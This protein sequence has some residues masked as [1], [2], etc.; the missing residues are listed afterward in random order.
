MR[1]L[2][3]TRGERHSFPVGLAVHVGVPKAL[4]LQHLFFWCR[5]AYNDGS[6]YESIPFCWKGAGDIAVDYPYM[7][8]RTISRHL[9]DLEKK[10]WIKR[11]RFSSKKYDKKYYYT[12]DF[13]RFEAATL[14][15]PCPIN[16]DWVEHMEVVIKK[17]EDTETLG[18]NVQGSGQNV[19]P[20]SDILDT[21]NREK[22][23]EIFIPLKPRF[24]FYSL[25]EMKEALTRWALDESAVAEAKSI[26][27]FK[28]DINLF[29]DKFVVKY[30]Q[31]NQNVASFARLH[32]DFL[33]W[34]QMEKNFSTEG[35]EIEEAMN[36]F[37]S[38]T[39]A[40]AEESDKAKKVMLAL[41]KME[42]RGLSSLSSSEAA[43]LA[44]AFGGTDKGRGRLKQMFS[45][46]EKKKYYGRNFNK[47]YD[48]LI[49][50]DKYLDRR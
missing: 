26:T 22:D 43:R 30:Y 32:S 7:E 13:S 39:K 45:A 27:L 36:A 34:M 5:V 31:R 24:S 9:A 40:D 10:G 33:R 12:V 29:I 6:L 47:L 20:I 38:I 44:A 1:E 4:I 49:E 2:E 19:Q 35:F 14:F 37:I 11:G 17:V 21:T 28:G 18:Q 25:V 46:V 3:K 48:A 15:L 42:V 23:R 41:S 16:V 8:I 50:A